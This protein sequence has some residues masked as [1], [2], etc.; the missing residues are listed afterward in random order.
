MGAPPK[1]E[2]ERR[3]QLL[4]A[5]LKLCTFCGKTKPVSE[6]YH[7]AHAGD[8]LMYNCKE[9]VTERNVRYRKSERGVEVG[10]ACDRNKN[11][12]ERHRRYLQGRGKQMRQR[13]YQEKIRGSVQNK[14]TTAVRMAVNRGELPRADSQSCN[15]CGKQA[16]VYHHWSYEQEHWLD[17]EPLCDKCHKSKHP[18]PTPSQT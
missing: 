10:R 6:F 15:C 2:R 16:R 5:G 17:V 1:E 7:D 4:A 13:Y 18:N 3:K 11:G 12:K 9:C 14:A 8:G